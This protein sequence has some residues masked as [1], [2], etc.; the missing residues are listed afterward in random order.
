M[1][2]LPNRPLQPPKSP[3]SHQSPLDQQTTVEQTP[4]SD[5][6]TETHEAVDES[7]RS[8]LSEPVPPVPQRP[9]MRPVARPTAPP[10]PVEPEPVAPPPVAIVTETPEELPPADGSRHQP[11]PAPSEPMQYRAIGCFGVDIP[12]PKSSL[13]VEHWLQPMGRRFKLCCWVEL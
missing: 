9:L 12:P 5:A 10:K 3:A 6:T 1:S 4:L 11:I 8:S 13:P 2:P 7:Q